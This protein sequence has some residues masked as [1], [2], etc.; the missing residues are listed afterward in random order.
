MSCAQAK[1]LLYAVK[2]IYVSINGCLFLFFFCLLFD[3]FFQIKKQHPHPASLTFYFKLPTAS[4]FLQNA[5]I[6]FPCKWMSDI[7]RVCSTCLTSCR[8]LALPRWPLRGGTTFR[9]RSLSPRAEWAKKNNRDCKSSSSSCQR[10]VLFRLFLWHRQAHMLQAVKLSG[11]DSLI[12]DVW[13][14]AVQTI[15]GEL[16]L[17]HWCAES[18][19]FFAHACIQVHLWRFLSL[20]VVLLL[21]HQPLV[22]E[23]EWKQRPWLLDWVP[24]CLTD[25]IRTRACCWRY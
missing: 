19:L 7:G 25:S 9:P 13:S 12:W 1:L 14:F 6:L 20:N 15:T 11:F 4:L 17:L 16:P 5:S 18:S 21:F 2:H 23:T 3:F 22:A 8:F 24:L 10:G